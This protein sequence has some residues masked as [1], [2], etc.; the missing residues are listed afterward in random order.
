MRARGNRGELIWEIW[1]LRR[2]RL[3]SLSPA[4]VEA[5]VNHRLREC[6]GVIRKWGSCFHL[7]TFG[8]FAGYWL[9]PLMCGGNRN[10]SDCYRGGWSNLKRRMSERDVSTQAASKKVGTFPTSLHL[11][12]VTA[13]CCRGI[14]DQKRYAVNWN[15]AWRSTFSKHW[16]EHLR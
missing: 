6:E 15:L 1:R 3:S 5:A 11:N 13:S 4:A 9:I 12:A 14:R 10:W 8:C 16:L 2:R 7:V